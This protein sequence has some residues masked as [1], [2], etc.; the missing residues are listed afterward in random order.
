M[1]LPF[2]YLQQLELTISIQIHTPHLRSWE[3]QRVAAFYLVAYRKP[4]HNEA[5]KRSGCREPLSPFPFSSSLA[6]LGTFDLTIS[7]HT[8]PYFVLS[9]IDFRRGGER[10][11]HQQKQN[12]SLLN[13]P[14][15]LRKEKQPHPPSVTSPLTH[16]S[17][18][19]W[20]NRQTDYIN[21]AGI[22]SCSALGT[23]CTQV[24]KL[25]SSRLEVKVC[26]FW[27]LYNTNKPPTKLMT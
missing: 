18:S 1:S 22:Q 24:Q 15:I 25:P 19:L 7:K 27:V 3:G 23:T 10:H 5:V 8:L 6:T 13:S 16:L 12:E 4:G 11:L 9:G 21:S 17:L 20:R 14:Y 26:C 2:S